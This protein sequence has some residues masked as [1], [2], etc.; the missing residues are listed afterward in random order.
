MTDNIMNSTT[1][2]SNV[3]LALSSLTH[4]NL[5]S[6]IEVLN[7]N[8]IVN[9]EPNLTNESTDKKESLN[10]DVHP[11]SRFLKNEAISRSKI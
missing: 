7:T 10:K 4:D 1:Y 2:D 9:T 11:K 8:S 5:H 3:L 6:S